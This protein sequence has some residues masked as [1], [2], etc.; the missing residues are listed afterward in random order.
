M[1]PPWDQPVSS[2]IGT[3]KTG[4]PQNVVAPIMKMLTKQM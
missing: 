4:M 3:T 1:M 2:L